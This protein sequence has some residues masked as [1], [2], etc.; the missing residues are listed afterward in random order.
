MLL[1]AFAALAI[2]FATNLPTFAEAPSTTETLASWNEGPAK[3]AIVDFVK[4]TTDKSSPDFVP[5][6][7][8]IAT[9]DQ[10]GTLWVE[11]PMYSQVVYCLD[12]VPA[13]VKAKPELADVEPFK[14]VVSGDR[15]AMA[16]LSTH[17]LEKILFATL[18]GMTVDTFNVEAKKWTEEAKDGRWKRPYTELTYQPMQE[19]LSYLRANDFKTYIVTGG[20]RISCGFILSGSMVS[21]LSRWSAVPAAQSTV[22]TRT[23]SRS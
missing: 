15:E 10:D 23:A 22:T 9:F 1:A 5:P 7:E 2:A 20:G 3:Q 11:H 14:T 8:R 4:A 21:H 6:E 17:D 13:L 12:R 19:V 18:T 16:K